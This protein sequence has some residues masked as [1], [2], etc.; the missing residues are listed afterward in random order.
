MLQNVTP[1]AIAPH[2]YFRR[3]QLLQAQVA[4]PPHELQKL[5]EVCGSAIDISEGTCSSVSLWRMRWDER[6]WMTSSVIFIG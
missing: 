5:L 1:D 4:Q 6:D 2:L 3:L